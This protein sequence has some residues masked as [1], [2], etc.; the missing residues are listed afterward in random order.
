MAMGVGLRNRVRRGADES[1]SY[2]S[3]DADGRVL[4]PARTAKQLF[5]HIAASVSLGFPDTFAANLSKSWSET[6]RL[7]QHV[8]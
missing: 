2:G 1:L 4:I 7:S 3:S 5:V 8:A 6:E